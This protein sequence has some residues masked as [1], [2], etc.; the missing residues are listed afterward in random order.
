MAPTAGNFR[1][2]F[3]FA[4]LATTAVIVGP[5][6]LQA[7]GPHR[8]LSQN[9]VLDGVDI[10]GGAEA[11]DQFGTATAVGDFNGDGIGDVAVG[12]PGEAVSVSEQGA[13]N[14]VYGSAHGLAGAGNQFWDLTNAALSGS[15]QSGDHFGAALAVGNLNGD[16]Y[17][18]LAIGVPGRDSDAGAVAI[19]Y[20]SATG[21]KT[22]GFQ[23]WSQNSS[24]GGVAIQGGE[25]SGDQFGAALS[26]GDFND[27]GVDDLAIG[28]PFEDLGYSSQGAVAVLYGA[29]GSGLVATGNQMFG[30]SDKNPA[31]GEYGHALSSGDFNGDDVT[32]LAVGIPG[33]R[34]CLNYVANCGDRGAVQVLSG[35]SAGLTGN[36]AATWYV[37]GVLTKND[38]PLGGGQHEDERFG[39]V[40][41]AG[42]FNGDSIADL[43]VG[44]PG[45]E[46]DG[47]FGAGSVSIFYGDYGGMTGAGGQVWTQNSTNVKGVA[48]DD[49]QFGFALA[50]GRFDENTT[51]D[52]AVGTPGD[53]VDGVAAGSVT[54]LFANSTGVT[55]ADQ[56]W[57]QN[58]IGTAGD[59]DDLYGAPEEDDRFGAALAPGD[60]FGRGF[61]G[62][63]VGLPGENAEAGSVNTIYGVGDTPRAVVP[64]WTTTSE[65]T[66]ATIGLIGQDPQGDSLTFTIVGTPTHGTLG[67]V[68]SVNG[69]S[70]RVQYT[71]GANYVGYDAFTFR[72]SDG[73]HVSTVATVSITVTAVNDP[74]VAAAWSTTTPE[75]VVAEVRL[76]ATDIDSPQ[77]GIHYFLHQ[78]P[79][80]GTVSMQESGELPVHVCSFDPS[81]KCTWYTPHENVSGWDS[82]TFKASDPLLYSDAATIAVI[83]TPV[84]DAPVASPITS[85]AIASQNLLVSLPAVDVD[86]ARSQLTFHL[87][88]PAA[89][90]G[91]VTMGANGIATYNSNGFWGTDGFFFNVF[92]SQDY[93]NTAWVTVNVTRVCDAGSY[94]LAGTNNCVLAP[95]GSFVAV[96]GATSPIACYPGTF[97]AS[98]GAVSCTPA[99][100]GTFIAGPGAAA[101]TACGP[102]SFSSGSGATRCTPAFPGTYVSE[103]GATSPLACPIGRYQP[104]AGQ[105]SCLFGSVC[106]AGF[107]M[108]SPA[109]GVTNTVCAPDTDNDG[110]LNTVDNCPAAANASQLDTDHD[111]PGDACDSDDD[112]DDVS[113]ATELELGTNPLVADTDGDSW[114]DI[115]EL[116]CSSD[117]RVAASLPGDNDL[118]GAINCDDPDDDNDGVLDVN[119][120]DIDGD[121]IANEIDAGPESRLNT[122]FIGGHGTATVCTAWNTI[123]YFSAVTGQM[124][125]KQ[126]C[127]A[128]GIGDVSLS[129]EVT[130]GA[131]TK[132]LRMFN[133]GGYDGIPNRTEVL[134]NPASADRLTVFA[135]GQ[136]VI[137]SDTGNYSFF[138][139]SLHLTATQGSV[140]ARL[141]G[142]GDAY[143]TVTNGSSVVVDPIATVNGQT[144]YRVTDDDA[145]GTVTV[146]TS[147]GT[148]SVPSGA[149]VDVTVAAPADQDADRVVDTVDNCRVTANRDQADLDGDAIG[150]VCDPDA[151]GD[152]V[153]DAA[154]GD[155]DHDG[156]LD[157][158]DNCRFAANADQADSDGDGI[159]DRC[160]GGQLSLESP[161]PVDPLAG[162][163]PDTDHDGVPDCIDPDAD[164]DG[165]SNADEVAAGLDP[166]NSDSDGDGAPDGA[167][168]WPMDATKSADILGPVISATAAITLAAESPGGAIAAYALPTAIDNIDGPAGVTCAPLSG[169][170]FPIGVTTVT[171]SSADATG[172]TS[173]STFTVTVNDVTAPGAMRGNGHLMSGGDRVEFIFEVRE[174]ASGERG[175]LSLKVGYGDKKGKSN[176]KDQKRKDDRFR[177]TAVTFVA[178]SDDPT[179]RP[180]RTRRAQVDT[181]RFQGTGEWNGQAGYTFEVTATDQGEPGRHHEEVTI[182]IRDSTGQI[183]A[184][185]AGEPVD[186]N[187]QST[188]IPHERGVAGRG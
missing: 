100:A 16:R 3:A 144:T 5:P 176:K 11:G 46:V 140:R 115:K 76:S 127:S 15:P 151:N 168:R 156:V 182:V 12:S 178:F 158:A 137:D 43:A 167:D 66:A 29:A 48:N 47:H 124:V 59:A 30:L 113:D 83:V 89:T 87:L 99:P 64:A 52:L 164:N 72:V 45:T 103:S 8:F 31:D 77:H 161:C 60:F 58:G 81:A 65:D 35:G 73:T 80:A 154:S 7:T 75:D 36:G 91:T 56:L 147:Q 10:T 74:P 94:R 138:C 40:L 141:D 163:A 101:P 96:A 129:G 153:A 9:S 134:V 63:V 23:L 98:P 22:A 6:I 145:R 130:S 174:R 37:T 97:S 105:A 34:G 187:V 67:A 1:F 28:V 38:V 111:G 117:P 139:G 92:D 173:T 82:F 126:A 61:D 146:T 42:D 179:I 114:S 172:N 150:D 148:L 183:V 171:C 131:G 133:S 185:V 155:S 93:S 142:T 128:W 177:S 20:G 143:V 160:D 50:A 14:V 49:E 159:G 116:A 79:S 19:L 27:D 108:V 121:G 13:V 184:E 4:V 2:R 54:I 180:G 188:R 162:V 175:K 44:A 104:D 102:G 123:S 135:C 88:N 84:N 32:D 165:S 119:D 169:A 166:F 33:Y 95:P 17:D 86:N 90:R 118:D 25:E 62:L 26:A 181:V 41:A 70:A 149:S 132:L 109:N 53:I 68:T 136:F 107:A 157:E 18:D 39:Q 112:N 21:L 57:T 24:L 106:Q 120:P 78:W 152:G 71:P 170:P 85:T 122:H 55:D 69:G 186:G 125:Y 110:I 51:V